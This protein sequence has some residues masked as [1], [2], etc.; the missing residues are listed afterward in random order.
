MR[1]S[2][3]V[4]APPTTTWAPV[5]QITAGVSVELIIRIVNAPMPR[6]TCVNTVVIKITA[7]G[8]SDRC[9]GHCCVT[10]MPVSRISKRDDN[11]AR[12]V[13]HHS[14]GLMTERR[15]QQNLHQHKEPE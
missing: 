5:T 3:P 7:A 9:V 4:S 11:C 12:Y 15:A 10:N 6:N 1:R 13:R 2:P 14:H 8:L